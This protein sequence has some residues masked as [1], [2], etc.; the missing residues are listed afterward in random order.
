MTDQLF[1][2]LPGNTLIALAN[3]VTVDI[4]T[5]RGR[6]KSRHFNFV[7]LWWRAY[8]AWSSI[9]SNIHISADRPN[10]V[11][12][13][14]Y[15]LIHVARGYVWSFCDVCFCYI[16]IVC[17]WLQF[18]VRVH[19]RLLGNFIW[20]IALLCFEIVCFVMKIVCFNCHFFC[21]RLYETR[22]TI[23]ITRKA[24]PWIQSPR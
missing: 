19:D 1:C 14:R 21:I 17:F 5:C 7:T 3:E 24:C 18:C 11:L 20:F 16:N 4:T 12:W 15:V 6:H 8:A 9:M 2:C 22:R 13:K 10:F 23:I